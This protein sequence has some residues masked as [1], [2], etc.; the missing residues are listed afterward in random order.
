M[1]VVN[2]LGSGVLENPGL[3]AFLPSIARH[4]L[5]EELKLPSAATWWCG[6]PREREHVLEN[7]ETLVIKPIY[8]G[9]DGGSVL[10]SQLTQAELAAWRQRIRNRPQLYVGQEQVDFSTAPSLTAGGMEP[11]HVI[12][13]TFLVAKGQTEK[14]QAEKD[15]A[16]KG[17]YSVL[18][19]GLARSARQRDNFVVNSS[20]QSL[21]KDVW[22][23]TEQ[24]ERPLSLWLRPDE[25]MP[26]AVTGTLPSRAAENL[27]WV[28]RYAERAEGGARWLRTVLRLH[29]EF[30][31]FSDAVSRQ[32][33]RLLLRGLTLLTATKPG[34]IGRGASQR[35]ARPEAELKSV[36]LK[37]E[38]AGSIAASV[39]GLIGAT[40]AVRDRWST[41]ALRV[42]DAIEAHWNQGQTV[43]TLGQV[44][45][46][47]DQL[48]I[49]LVAFTGLNMES[50]TRALGWTVLDIGRRLERA[51]L[52]CVA[53]RA[54]AVPRQA[55]ATEDMALEGLLTAQ[56]SLI[57][58]RNRYRS[59]L[60]LETVLDLLLL[61]STNPRSL[62]YQLTRLEGHIDQL[63]RTRR[64]NRLSAEESA[65][66]EA[67]AR[68]RLTDPQALVLP[69]GAAGRRKRLDLLLTQTE[70]ALAQVS[71]ML[72]QTYFAHARQSHSLTGP[73]AAAGALP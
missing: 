52:L 36:A 8:S 5:D 24:P 4:F 11:R 56:E 66:A 41:D 1:A 25:D 38:R 61:D 71:D 55:Q 50:M 3:M 44:R 67:V 14:G 30:E 69:E 39:N 47:L 7:L 2:P 51:Q 42:L 29:I 21:S 23:L 10:G 57:T 49:D 26:R 40:H 13:R 63:P 9:P 72:N 34:F 35:L 46:A 37:V 20:S 62:L 12:L 28:G 68:L 43:S 64:G 31:D 6:Q 48:V 18:P 17:P 16:G 73:A 22:V 65:I 60:H 15:P 45:N 53:L 59:Y 19:G 32:A 33:M 54:C 70:T 27:F 58:Y